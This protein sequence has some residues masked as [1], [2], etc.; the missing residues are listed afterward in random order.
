MI[1]VA[2]RCILLAAILLILSLPAGAQSPRMVLVEEITNASC[3]PCAEQNPLFERYLDMPHNEDLVIPVIF[4]S[5]YPGG[6]VM[7][8]E[9]PS[10][11]NNRVGI[12]TIT[13]VPTALVNG[14]RATPS[15]DSYAGAPGDTLAIS[16]VVETHRGSTS[17]ITIR[18]TQIRN[19]S[20]VNGRVTV[21]S[22]ERLSGVK[23]YIVAVERHR[24]YG[25]AGTNGERDFH[26]IAREMYPNQGIDLA[27]EAGEQREVPVTFSIPTEMKPEDIYFVAFVQNPTTY[28]VLQAGTSRGRLTIESSS[29]LAQLQEGSESAD[30]NATLGSD[31]SRDYKVS[32]Q[33]QAPAGWESDLFI[34]ETPV[35]NGATVRITRETPAAMRVVIAP[36]AATPG[37]GSAIVTLTGDQGTVLTRRFT[38]YS[39]GLTALVIARD[40]GNPT[41]ATYYDQALA[42]GPHSY[43]VVEKGDDDLFDW[44]DHIII[45][46]VGRW[47]IE[48]GEVERLKVMFDRG[49]RL[50]LSGAEIAFGLVDPRSANPLTGRDS[51]FL[52]NYLHADYLNDGTYDT[53]AV[54]GFDGDPIGGGLSFSIANGVRNQ[55]TPDEIAPRDGAR[56]VFFYGGNQQR[57]A[58]I[59]YSDMKNR[60]V[61]LGFGM[62]GI[63]SAAT[64][65]EVMKRC[66]DWLLGEE[67]TSG[68]TDAPIDLE[69]ALASP[70]PTPAN[71]SFEIPFRLEHAS[72]VRIT[73]YN[74]RGESIATVAN[75]DFPAGVSSVRFD[76]SR[77][78]TGTYVVAMQAGERTLTLMMQVVR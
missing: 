20:S 33:M 12:Y 45:Y 25:N 8:A 13:A 57:I 30:W 35:E 3:V 16:R 78:A 38:C 61:Y 60:L 17:P 70:R 29:R 75:D 71:G 32:V 6:D 37:K 62:E 48:K 66:V 64:R 11:H 1:P 34:D 5:R 10:M 26:Y 15:G 51:A 18:A 74:T 36:S 42:R 44:N 58:A 49:G 65:G 9:N 53:S 39:S 63:G 41:I 59:R 7:N 50:L 47:A 67:I 19:G 52:A 22:V 43:A 54:R 31:G 4:H 73:L 40:E 76:G 55:Q 14:R 21:S 56:P 68:V 46:E 28:E 24:Y 69:I 77:L 27:L 72:H 23:L 2:S